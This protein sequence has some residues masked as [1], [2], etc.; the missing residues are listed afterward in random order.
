MLFYLRKIA[1]ENDIFQPCWIWCFA[2]FLRIWVISKYLPWSCCNWS[3]R[4]Q[5][6]DWRQIKEEILTFLGATKII[7]FEQRLMTQNQNFQINFLFLFPVTETSGPS[8]DASR[9]APFATSVLANRAWKDSFTTKFTKCCSL[10]DQRRQTTRDGAHQRLSRLRITPLPFSDKL[11]IKSGRVRVRGR[12]K[13][14]FL[15]LRRQLLCQAEGK[16]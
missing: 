5:K 1:F 15:G 10:S 14:V 7:Q 6:K 11:S 16:N 3:I 12:V 2:F 8:R 9:F 13:Y 4:A